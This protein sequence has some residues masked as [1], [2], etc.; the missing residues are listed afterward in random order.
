MN[1]TNVNLG[2]LLLEFFELYGKKFD[3]MH[4]AISV[5]DGGKYISKN[6]VPIIRM[7]FH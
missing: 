3:Y 1:S 2:V 6:E 4:D 5:K 7:V